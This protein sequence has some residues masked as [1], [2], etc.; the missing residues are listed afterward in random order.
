MSHRR[1]VWCVVALVLVLSITATACA[2]SGP[3]VGPAGRHTL[4]ARTG[5]FV[6]AVGIF[7]LV[8]RS[9]NGGA[10]WGQVHRDRNAALATLWSAAFANSQRGWAVG[11]A[12]IIATKDGG[13]HWSSQRAGSLA[14]QF[15]AVACSSSQH[16][17]AVGRRE[18]GAGDPGTSAAILSTRN[19]GA[20]WRM[21]TLPQLARLNGVAFADSRHGWAV[22]E[23]KTQLYGVIIATSDGGRHWHV[24]QRFK[25]TDFTAVACT[26][27][28]HVW[29]VGGP[30]EFPVTGLRPTPP[31]IVTTS[32]G[33]THW[34]T[35]LAANA[36]TGG[37]LYG[38]DFVDGRHG[39]VVGP[40]VVL[41]TSD[42]GL[43]WQDRPP[44]A[45]PSAD[46]SIYDSVSFADAR[47][48]WIVV[49]HHQLLATSD[50]GTTW[51]VIMSLPLQTDRSLTGVLAFGPK[52]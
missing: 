46:R 4:P 8:M 14:L 48:G 31:M 38:V 19:G 47:H 41:A 12:S 15:D 30:I 13:L 17:W 27:A 11:M 9:S 18:S 36:G 7:N 32:D 34:H 44:D 50:G 23:D 6:Y 21:Q 1:A 42:G 28:A 40:G 52:S 22:G 16:A 25:W 39:W 37:D 33:G 20:T 24:Q 10:T 45:G 5:A 35:Q 43:T 2:S 3:Q 49:D 26:D 51:Q 29:A